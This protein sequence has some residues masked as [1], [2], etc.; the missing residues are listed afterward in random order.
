MQSHKVQTPLY[1]CSISCWKLSLTKFQLDQSIV[2]MYC[3]LGENARL[4]IVFCRWWL[5]ACI[6]LGRWPHLERFDNILYINP[7]RGSTL[8]LM[9]KIIWR[10]TEQGTVICILSFLLKFYFVTCRGLLFRRQ[11]SRQKLLLI[12]IRFLE[13]Y[14]QVYKQVNVS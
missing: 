8:P 1:F 12:Q 5:Y 9:R 7:P 10:F 2:H 14:L 6:V 4:F 11:H 3:I 13:K